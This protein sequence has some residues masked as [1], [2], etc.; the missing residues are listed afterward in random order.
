M[1]RHP[2]TLLIATAA[3]LTGCPGPDKRPPLV[4]SPTALPDARVGV[5]Y[6]AEIR[7]V[8]NET[9]VIG[10][11]L[12]SGN[13]PPGL[14]LQDTRNGARIVGTPK[15]A[16]RYAF[17]IAASCHGTQVSG[18]CGRASYDLRVVEGE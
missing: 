12:A 17:S 8:N 18:Q 13:L 6:S 5:P 7:T 1:I 10:Y 14:E 3:L 11:R 4:F 16:G 2:A 9:P 15:Q